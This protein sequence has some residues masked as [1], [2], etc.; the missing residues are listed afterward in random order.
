MRWALGIVVLLILI[1]MIRHYLAMRRNLRKVYSDPFHVLDEQACRHERMAHA[2]R[3]SLVGALTAGLAHE[4]NTPLGSALSVNATRH[5][6]QQKFIKALQKRDPQIMD[7]PELAK[8]YK[9]L[10]END[11]ILDLGLERVGALVAQ[12]K[13]KGRK[14]STR[15]V[16]ADIARRID[17]SLLLLTNQFKHRIEIVR[18]YQDVPEIHC[19]PSLLDQVFLNL[20]VNASNAIEGEGRI[21]VSLSST[22]THLEVRIADTGQGI[23]P[24]ALKKIFD[25]GYTTRGD[26]G[27]TGLGLPISRK[28]IEKHHGTLT[29]E[30]SSDQGTTFLIRLPMNLLELTDGGPG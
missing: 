4:I 18:D 17:G 10:Q 23:K 7:D 12:L 16:P 15:P 20:L 11:A 29:V 22:D 2:D 9:I 25:F 21:T 19:L 14:E 3:M 27:G 24:E 13:E 30:S 6:A 5:T 28:V 1:M 8:I 26:N